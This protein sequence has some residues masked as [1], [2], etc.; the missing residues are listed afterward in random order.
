MKHCAPPAN[1]DGKRLRIL[2]V[3]DSKIIKKILRSLLKERFSLA[4]AKDGEVGVQQYESFNPHIILLDM[5]MPR[6]SGLEVIEHIRKVA[7]D[8]D[9]YIIVFTA[10]D[11]KTLKARALNAGAN[12]FLS[13]SYDKSELF[14]RI[15]VAERQV[16]LNEQIR[17]AYEKISQEIQLAA[18]LQRRLH[19]LRHPDFE[20]GK[21]EAFFEP[22]GQASGDFFDAFRIVDGKLRIV[23]A[24]VSGTGARAALIQTIVRTLFR[25]TQENFV[26]LAQLFNQINRHLLDVLRK[27]A[28]FVTAFAADFDFKN[29]KLTYVNAGHC[30]AVLIQAEEMELLYAKDPVMGFFEYD[31]RESEKSI[32]GQADLFLYTDGWYEWIYKNNKI[33]GLENF[34]SLVSENLEKGSFNMQEL[35]DSLKKVDG[36]PPH[37]R[38]DVTA[39]WVRINSPGMHG[40]RYKDIAESTAA[41]RLTREAITELSNYLADEEALAELE[42]ALTEACTNTYRHAYPENEKGPLEIR[43]SVNEGQSVDFEVVDW[44]KGFPSKARSAIFRNAPP[45]AQSGRGLYMISRISNFMEI[46]RSGKENILYFH[47]KLRKEQWKK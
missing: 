4:D 14:A 36:S 39:L 29:S 26:S 31:F 43:M 12:D 30:P 21:I 17:D 18:D 25:V 35:F 20:W 27:E 16:H 19:P 8:E 3:D 37:F 40:F 28:D 22:S 13:K 5:N 6:K 9:V 24:D 23:I 45:E 38:D 44:G 34:I 11:D 10:S 7:G 2:I 15:G 1:R 42:L 33:Y 47:K 46:R 41:R 32:S